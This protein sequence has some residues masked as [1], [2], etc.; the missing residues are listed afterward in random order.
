VI[1]F[2]VLVI[3]LGILLGIVAL[4]T[5][6]AIGN[7]FYSSREE[8]TKR[9]FLDRLRKSFLLLKTGIPED[10]AEGMGHIVRGLG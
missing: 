6:A 10:H 4:T 7:K 8:S 1:D 5:L 2:Q 3:T 9:S